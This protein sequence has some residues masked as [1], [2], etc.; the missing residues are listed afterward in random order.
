MTIKV[1]PDLLGEIIAVLA[2][3]HTTTT[4]ATDLNGYDSSKKWVRIIESPGSE[5]IPGRLEAPSFDFN[6][7]APNIVD[8]RSLCMAVKSTI[9]GMTNHHTSELVITKVKIDVTP[10]DLTDL[11]NNQPR[12]IFTATIYYRPK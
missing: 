10:Y 4:I 1:M 3:A 11:T 12:Y 5:I 9:Q 6:V 7:Y 8:T 2:A